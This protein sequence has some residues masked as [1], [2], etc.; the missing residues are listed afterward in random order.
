MVVVV[1]MAVLWI[2]LTGATGRATGRMRRP[3]AQAWTVYVWEW[4]PVGMQ[5]AQFEALVNAV[6][7]HGA[8][9]R[10]RELLAAHRRKPV[11]SPATRCVPFS[12]SLHEEEEL[13]PLH[14]RDRSS[15]PRWAWPK[16]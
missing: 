7:E 6:D 9:Q 14:E 12:S 10:A 1:V 8:A 16:A 4:G 11:L 15:L 2:V 5:P 13:L 3:Q